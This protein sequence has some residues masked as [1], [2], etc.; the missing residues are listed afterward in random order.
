VLLRQE[1]FQ[2]GFRE[3][4]L[5]EQEVSERRVG[6]GHGLHAKTLIDLL[7]SANLLAHGQFPQKHVFTPVHR[8]PR[9]PDAIPTL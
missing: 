2:L 7:L 3:V 1:V 4:S 8:R 5:E 9:R 6:A